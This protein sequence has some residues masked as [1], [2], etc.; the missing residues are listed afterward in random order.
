MHGL[1]SAQP[2]QTIAKPNKKRLQQQKNNAAR[3]PYFLQ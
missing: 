1:H 2:K 3:A